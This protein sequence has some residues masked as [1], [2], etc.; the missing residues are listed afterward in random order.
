MWNHPDY[1]NNFSGICI[2]YLSEQVQ[3]PDFDS[4]F[5][6]VKGTVSTRTPY[7]L[8]YN[9]DYYFVLKKVE[10]DNDRLHCYNPFKEA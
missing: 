2:G 10:Y 5:I 9:S 8:K 4:Y 3:Q 6:K 7:F 1:C